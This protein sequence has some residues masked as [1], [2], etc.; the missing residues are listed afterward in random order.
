MRRLLEEHRQITTITEASNG[1]QA[2]QLASDKSFDIVLLDINLPGIGGIETSNKLLLLAPE[3]RII[4]VTGN[5]EGGHIRQ[6]LNAGVRGYITK[7]SSAEEMIEAID[8]VIAGKQYLSADVA[9]H[10]AMEMINGSEDNPFEKLTS[11]ETEIINLLLSG[12]RNR[13]IST[14]LFI[15]EK[16][17]SSHRI[18]AF[19]KL[20]VKTTAELVRLAMR[21]NM[22]V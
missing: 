14:S 8:S 13:Q 4:I 6:L 10:M 2:L 7:G 19:E 18:R 21:Y 12:H 16:T 3:I 11:R 1:E 22:W 17:V 5:L 9:Q 15:S 20:G